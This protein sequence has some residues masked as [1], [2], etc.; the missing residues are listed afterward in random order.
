[1]G[2]RKEAPVGSRDIASLDTRRVRMATDSAIQWNHRYSILWWNRHHTSKDRVFPVTFRH[3]QIRLTRSSK[4]RNEELLNVVYFYYCVST[5]KQT[6]LTRT[7]C[8]FLRV[9]IIIE[10]WSKIPK[11]ARLKE[12]SSQKLL[13]IGAQISDG[14]SSLA[15]YIDMLRPKSRIVLSLADVW[16]A[17]QV[18]NTIKILWESKLA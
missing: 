10:Y 1:M 11:F 3:F 8:L 17:M 9:R 14:R 18:C 2:R 4:L 15:A 13:A 12:L 6:K 16:R 7:G 5:P